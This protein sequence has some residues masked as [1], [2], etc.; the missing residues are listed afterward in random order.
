M[1]LE[2]DDFLNWRKME[3]LLKINMHREKKFFTG[4]EDIQELLFLFTTIAISEYF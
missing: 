3:N 2:M 4:Y 1:I